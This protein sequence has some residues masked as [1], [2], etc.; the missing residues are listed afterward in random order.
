MTKP[1]ISFHPLRHKAQVFPFLSGGQLY[2]KTFSSIFLGYAKTLRFFSRVL[3][4]FN[5][6]FRISIQQGH[7]SGSAK[8]S[9]LWSNLDDALLVL[10]TIEIFSDPFLNF[11]NRLAGLSYP[12]PNIIVMCKASEDAWAQES[13]SRFLLK[14]L[15]N[16][17]HRTEP[18]IL[19]FNSF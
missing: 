18:C 6:L 1:I 4:I 2:L 15:K 13:N 19:P 17:R 12:F 10:A 11:S 14:L 3:I 5:N 7:I 8:S 16:T 9:T